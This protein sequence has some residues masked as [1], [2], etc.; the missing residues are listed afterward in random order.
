M[1]ASGNAAI[2][3]GQVAPG[4]PTDCG[5]RNTLQ[6]GVGGPPSYEVPSPGGVITTWSI[7]EDGDSGVGR[8]QLWRSVGGNDRLLV[9]RSALEQTTPGIVNQFQTRIP[10]APGAVLGLR[11]AD[12]T[13]DCHFGTGLGLDIT[14]EEAGSSDPV[15]GETRTI[16][17]SSGALRVNVSATLEPDA[18]ND[19]F[20]DETQD[21]CP[22]QAGPNGGCPE[23]QPEPV[24]STAPNAAITSGPKDRTG[25]P[26]ATFTFTGTDARAVTSFVC[27]LDG[28]A[29]R[30]C[31]SPVTYKVKTGKHTFQ[32]QAIDEAGNVGLPVTDTWKRKRKK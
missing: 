17:P 14:A 12:D 10:A 6:A 27:S 30:A 18:D 22:D 9:A 11:A 1:P 7:K 16:G 24:D 25:K 5:T 8:L 26:T 23:P 28:E 20:G 2:Q 32:V 4:T 15:P 29:P 19:G 3:L 13:L 21:R 31:S